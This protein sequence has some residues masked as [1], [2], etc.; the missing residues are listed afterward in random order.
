MV[1][2][3][4]KAP[5][6]FEIN[7]PC[8]PKKP[9]VISD[10]F[11]YKEN[12]LVLNWQWNHNPDNN[13][14]SLT[15]RPG[16]LRLETGNLTNSVVY[17]RNTL[18][19]RTEGPACIGAALMD[20]SNM[21]PG[22]SAGLVALQGN[23]GTVGIKV[24]ENGDKYVTMCVKDDNDGEKIVARNQFQ[25]NL[26]YLKIEF[27]FEDSIDIAD[28]YYSADG[29]EW[30]K[31]GMPL[32]MLYTLDHFMGYRIGLFN[33]ATRQTGGYVDFDYFHYQRRGNNY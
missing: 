16:Y 20:I 7:L 23:F 25:G 31:I 28:F 1:G 33:Y 24:A 5:K 21:K 18:T 2:I 6:E 15:K 29:N 4:G 8:T 3:E 19:Q 27:N 11:D 12:R 10:E 13:L 26:I 32:K 14:W 30:S 9:L 17:A 22:D